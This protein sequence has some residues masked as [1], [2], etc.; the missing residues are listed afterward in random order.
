V[1]KYQ[2]TDAL[3]SPVAVSNQTGAVIDRTNYDPYGGA[4][5]KTMD[6]IGYTGHV[7]DPVTGLTYMQ[8][9]YYDPAIGRFLS[10][11]PVTASSVTGANFNR[12]WYA[13]NNPY[14][15]IDPDGRLAKDEKEQVTGSLIS[16]GGA[17]NNVS[18]TQYGPSASEGT[19]S[20]QGKNYQSASLGGQKGGGG[21]GGGGIFPRDTVDAKIRELIRKGDWEQAA[22]M[23]EVT[24]GQISPATA[25]M[26]E[27]INILRGSGYTSN[28]ITHVFKP[29]HLLDGVVK[30]AGSQEAAMV[31]IH[32]AAQVLASNAPNGTIFKGNAVAM[33]GQTIIVQGR[34]IDGTLRVSSAWIKP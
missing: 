24:G 1:V 22:S 11:D 29:K 17:G 9:R 27:A 23:L 32:R 8:Q 10:V 31:Q 25:R 6:G 26:V 19:S 4:I 2:H 18:I 14:R 12:Y 13:N 15:F 3:G 5:N 34:V 20:S 16:G 30:S 7:M 21:S 33:G 28:T